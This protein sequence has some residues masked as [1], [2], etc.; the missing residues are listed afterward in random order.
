MPS[1][2]GQEFAPRLTTRGLHRPRPTTS[3][4]RTNPSVDEWTHE[5]RPR[6]S[7][8]VSPIAHRRCPDA[9]DGVLGI[10]G[11]QCPKSQRGPELPLDDVDYAARAFT[12]QERD[13]K[14]ANGH[15]LV[16]TKAIIRFAGD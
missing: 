9:R 11:R 6:W 15:D 5:P 4:A 10:V 12:G 14:S 2:A 13:P 16:G 8:V 3:R 1:Q 7:I